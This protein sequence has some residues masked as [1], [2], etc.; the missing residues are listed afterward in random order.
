MHISF[1]FVQL[2]P[3]TSN[4][5]LLLRVQFFY[6][7]IPHIIILKLRHNHRAETQN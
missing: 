1:N 4:Y 6:A 3:T 7:D 2:V 5:L